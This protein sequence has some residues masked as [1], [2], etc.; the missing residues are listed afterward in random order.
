MIA[1]R[2]LKEVFL[3]DSSHP[4]HFQ[5]EM[6]TAEKLAWIRTAEH[7]RELLAEI[8]AEAELSV[9][10]PMPILDFHTFKKF[11]E[12][13]TRLEYEQLYFGRRGRLLSLSLAFIIDED[14]KF[15]TSLEAIVWEICNEYSWALPAHLSY[16]EEKDSNHKLPH[17]VVDLFAAETAQALAEMLALVGDR[18]HPWIAQR[19]HQEIERR[20]FD[21]CFGSKRPF[22]WFSADHNWAA[23]CGGAV[24]VAAML[25]M[26]D[27]E[28]LA[29]AQT[30]VV[31]AMESFLSGYGEDGCCTEGAGYWTYGFGYYVYWAEMLYTFTNGEIN[32]LQNDKARRIAQYASKVTLTSPDCVNYSDCES[33]VH[34]HPGLMSRL[35]VRLH[36][37]TP[38]VVVPPSFHKDHTYRWAH[39]IR[40]LFWYEETQ[41]AESG[42]ISESVFFENAAWIIDKKATSSGLFAFSTK[43][44][45]NDEPHNH[46]DLG[47]FI[48]H[49]A[50]DTLLSDLGPGMYTQ[51]YFG[52]RRYEHLHT[53]S[54]GHSVP[55]INGAVQQSGQD[56]TAS[57]LQNEYSESTLRIKLDLTKAYG[58]ES[59]LSS[60][61]RQF[62][63]SVKENER[64]SELEIEDQFEF[65]TVTTY[66]II[67]HLISLYRP[68]LQS[69]V[70]CWRGN[71]GQ[72]ELQYDPSTL[73]AK[74]EEV[75]THKHLGESQTVY[76]IALR[77]V[78]VADKVSLK[79]SLYGS[80]L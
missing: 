37:H 19:V 6:I 3:K 75:Q 32:M 69:G 64:K 14:Q 15:L 63:W 7:F 17:D 43:G 28:R 77:A 58:T 57:V 39:Q 51:D 16:N 65:T 2:Q 26:T 24:G 54:L 25:L 72:A 11:H 20:V 76:R 27:R 33:E 74:V 22:F 21:P 31:N 36:I 10:E 5:K 12:Q 66:E 49:I 1:Y 29:W 9:S 67:E 59:G 52:E 23:V 70:I 41:S 60:Y 78:G 79:W 73:E 55:V 34:F 71:R 53:S 8:R 35:R 30:K 45:H 48:L 40:N 80:A 44:G 56:Y 50:G 46:N 13:G 68:I 38:N 18:L 62:S 42:I 4:N 47:H 61:I